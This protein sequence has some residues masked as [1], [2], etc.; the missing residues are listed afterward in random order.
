MGQLKTGRVVPK[1]L[2]CIQKQDEG[3]ETNQQN[4]SLT[5]RTVTQEQLPPLAEIVH[6]YYVK[7]NRE[8]IKSAEENIYIN[9]IKYLALRDSCSQITIC[10]TDII[11]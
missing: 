5:D 2:Y 11:P 8:L 6:C 3:S 1:K 10:H 9:N 4:D 7:T